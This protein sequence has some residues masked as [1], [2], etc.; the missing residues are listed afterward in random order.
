MY[1]YGYQKVEVAVSYSPRGT[2]GNLYTQ[3][4]WS[5]DGHMLESSKGIRTAWG[6]PP[7]RAWPG[8][9]G[10]GPGA[11]PLHDKNISV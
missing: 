7:G 6:V 9:S 1:K 4:L 11:G 5:A 8:W 10:P 2:L 3:F